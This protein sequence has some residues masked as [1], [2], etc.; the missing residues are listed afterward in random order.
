M[1]RRVAPFRVV[2]IG[3]VHSPVKLPDE[4]PLAGVPAS[5]EVLP[6]FTAA[7]DGIEEHSHL[8]VLCHMDGA[9]RDVLRASPRKLGAGLPERGVFAMRSP[10]RPNPVGLC[11]VK[12]VRREGSTLHV[13]P[14]DAVDGTAVLDIKPYA[15]GWD[16]VF[17]AR[18][19]RS[20]IDARLPFA[21]G[22]AD[23]LRI[24]GNFHGDV[25]PGIVIGAR[26]TLAGLRELGLDE[27]RGTKRLV[28]FVESDRCVT[29]AVM[30][31]TGCTPGRR[32][33][34][35]VDAGK[36]AATF[37]DLTTGRAVRVAPRS[38]PPSPGGPHTPADLAATSRTLAGMDESEL[39]IITDVRVD[40]RNEDRPG[41][42]SVSVICATCGETVHDRRDVKANGLSLCTHCAGQGYY[43]EV[44][45]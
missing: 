39:L 44:G 11:V 42:P 3:V 32:T 19:A 16:C 38:R 35:V 27:P 7:L 20:M 5:V 45:K 36:M 30:A 41:P 22:L 43:T 33:L 34:K 4:M 1:E 12:L 28:V 24:A 15:Y 31:L 26:A 10:A 23:A 17:S 6:E 25:C 21:D 40:L 14:L 13:E 37:L 9:G 29:D 2:P 18:S 8:F